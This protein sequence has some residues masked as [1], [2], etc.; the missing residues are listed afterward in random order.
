MLVRFWNVSLLLQMQT[1]I[2]A[3]TLRLDAISLLLKMQ[4]VNFTHYV[5]LTTAMFDCL[6]LLKK[7]YIKYLETNTHTARVKYK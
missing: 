4:T 7:R 1:V 2:L 5:Q 6:V 3:H